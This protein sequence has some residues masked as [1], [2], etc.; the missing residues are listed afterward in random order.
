M[1]KIRKGDRVIVLSGKDKGS[2][3]NVVSVD[4][5]SDRAVVE[6]IN[7]A[8]KSQRPVSE[9]NMGGIVDKNMPIRLCK[10]AVVSPSDGKAT[11]VGFKVNDDGTKVRIC[12]RTGAEIS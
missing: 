9:T 3:G 6:G 1:A 12:K 2:E 4:P 10:L 11:R 5:K 8:R 7:V